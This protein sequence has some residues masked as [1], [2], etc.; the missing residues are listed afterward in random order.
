MI[1]LENETTSR[2]SI[3]R[4]EEKKRRRTIIYLI[5]TNTSRS[6]LSILTTYELRTTYFSSIKALKLTKFFH[7]HDENEKC[8]QQRKNIIWINL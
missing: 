7:V 1:V 6:F 3:I 4:K 2:M 5:R 8:L